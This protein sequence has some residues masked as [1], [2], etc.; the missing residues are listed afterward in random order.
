MLHDIQRDVMH[1]PA[2]TWNKNSTREEWQKITNSSRETLSSASQQQCKL[3]WLRIEFFIKPVLRRKS[4]YLCLRNEVSRAR[5][6]DE[7]SG[8]RPSFLGEVS[9][10]DKDGK[11]RNLTE[12]S[13]REEPPRLRGSAS[14]PQRTT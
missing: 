12:T 6:R 1:V 7:L 5:G 11:S 13:S 3:G 4:Q 10:R 9:Q 2:S 8:L 14:A